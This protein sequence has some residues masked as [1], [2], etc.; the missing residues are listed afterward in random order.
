MGMPGGGLH[1]LYI[2]SGK[3]VDFLFRIVY[4]MNNESPQ[5]RAFAYEFFDIITAFLANNK[6]LLEN[7]KDEIRCVLSSAANKLAANPDN[8][9]EWAADYTI[10]YQE[11]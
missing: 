11:C 1:D 5:E 3:Q 4:K 2:G 8:S 9:Q 10:T 7:G 6:I